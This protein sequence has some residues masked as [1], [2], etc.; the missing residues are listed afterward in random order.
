[1][2]TKGIPGCNE[3]VFSDS[4]FSVLSAELQSVCGETHIHSLKV[5]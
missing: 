4:K 2:S 5:S 3:P 1:M